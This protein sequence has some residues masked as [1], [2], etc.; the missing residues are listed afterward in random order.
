MNNLNK[1]P[2]IET[3]KLNKTFEVKS[4]RIPVLKDITATILNGEFVVITGPS[5]CG[6]S[7]L[8]HIL[9]G[10]EPPT[11]GNV[12]FFDQDLYSHL[13]EDGRT[14]LRKKNVGMVYQQPNWIKALTVLENVMF[15][16]RINGET[17][18]AARKKSQET[19]A[20]VGMLDWQDFIPTELSSGQQQ[21]IALARA[22][23][24]NPKVIIA[25][26]PTGNLDFKSG[27][28]LMQLLKKLNDAG[29]TIVMVTHDLEYLNFATRSL[30]MFDGK[31]VEEANSRDLS[32]KLTSFKK[33]FSEVYQP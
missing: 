13:D 27:E 5:G 15:A 29:K 1:T 31:I 9:L 10:L 30:I 7:T 16:L 8:L 11:S 19:L 21:K 28:E 23:I 12:S 20:M 14:E 17:D 24:T 3:S 26:E 6:K 25:D 4:S 22:V 2:I 33:L 32:D 18:E